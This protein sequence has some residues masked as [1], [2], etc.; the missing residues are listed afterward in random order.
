VTRLRLGLIGC[1]GIARDVHLR[2][3]RRLR[4]V[5]V[6]ALADPSASALAAAG[7]LAPRAGLHADAADLL[8]RDDVDA[9]VVCAATASHAALALAAL[10]SGRHL[11]LEKPVTLTVEDGER[12][13]AAA[14]AAGVVAAVGFN[15]RFHPLVREARRRLHD[16]ELG[17]VVRA[18]TVFAEPA[19]AAGRPPWKLRRDTGGG[20]PLLLSLHHVDLLRFLLGGE[21]VAVGGAIRSIESEHD[22][23][24]LE[25]RFDGCDA[26]VACSFVRPRGDEIELEDARGRLLRLSRYE[27]T[28]SLDGRPLLALPLLGPRL[29]A[30]LRRTGDVS[31]RA[32]LAAFLARVRGADVELPTLEDGLASLRAVLAAE[33]LA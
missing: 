23:C 27:G 18:R 2:N 4:G 31:Y 25:F 14:R 28:L 24:D 9:V 19:P 16:G 29:R 32:A 6:V 1:G 8:S 22:D 5:E 26:L 3:A 7:A 17:P 11:Y 15:R 30:A 13:V 33:R 10:E 12:V 20:A 21:A